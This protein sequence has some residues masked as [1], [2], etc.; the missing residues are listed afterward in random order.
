MN[1]KQEIPSLFVIYYHHRSSDL[2]NV[3]LRL[4]VCYS[5]FSGYPNDRL[6]SR[7]TSSCTYSIWQCSGFSPDSLIR[8]PF[9]KTE[10]CPVTMQCIKLNFRHMSERVLSLQIIPLS[11][12]GFLIF[13]SIDEHINKS[14]QRFSNITSYPLRQ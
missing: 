8:T 7:I 14:H 13:L 6:T 10:R 1:N 3:E 9:T 5:A 12:Y 11:F 2:C 4:C